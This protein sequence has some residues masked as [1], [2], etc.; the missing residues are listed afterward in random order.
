MKV[1]HEFEL[2]HVGCLEHRRDATLLV[3]WEIA[4]DRRRLV[5]V[6]C[7]HPGFAGA[8]NW[9]CRWTCLEQLGA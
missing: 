1:S 3:E 7:D 9:D 2:V 6:S 4:A 5:G 8:D